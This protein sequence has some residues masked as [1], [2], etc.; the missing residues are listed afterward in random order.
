MLSLLLIA[1]LLTSCGSKNNKS[2]VNPLPNFDAMWNYQHPDSTEIVFKEILLTLQNNSETSY[3][4]EYHAELLTQI[5]RTQGLQR[6]FEEA[7]KTLEVAKMLLTENI[8]TANIRYLLEKG[9]LFYSSAEKEKAKSIFLE[10]YQFG[11]K[12][13]L[14]FYALDAAH[15]MGIVEPIDK[16]IEWSLKA[17]K[18]AEI[19]EDQRCKG[20]LGTLYNNIGWSYHDKNKFEEALIYFQKG[21]DW[22]KSIND[23]RGARIAKWTIG[24]TYRSMGKIEKALEIQLALKVEIE[25]KKLPKDGYVFEELAELYLSNNENILSKKYFDLAYTILSQDLWLMTNEQD[26]LKRLKKLGK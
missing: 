10:A 4:V 20:W 1:L 22:R 14:D 15:M 5:A 16:Q 24:R 6:K 13:N 25:E 17:L 23:E 3:D 21:L 11:K 18:I 26:R 2:G 7:E 9:R 19:S 12:N 8:K